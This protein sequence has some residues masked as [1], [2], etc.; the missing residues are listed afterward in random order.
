MVVVCVVFFCIQNVS[1]FCYFLLL[2]LLIFIIVIFFSLMLRFSVYLVGG[3]F[4]ACSVHVFELFSLLFHGF[5]DNDNCD[6]QRENG[7]H[8]RNASGFTDANVC[9]CM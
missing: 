6:T 8:T 5:D 2:L 3:F 1:I 4:P 7:V 9:N